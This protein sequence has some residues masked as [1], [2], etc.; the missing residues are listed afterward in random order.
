MTEM[1]VT[2]TAGTGHFFTNPRIICTWRPL[3][4]HAGYVLPVIAVAE[5]DPGFY[6]KQLLYVATD[7]VIEP[8]SGLL[9]NVG[10]GGDCETILLQFI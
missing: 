6:L 5:G 10:K 1:A 9:R 8:H 2:P 4:C 7:I 3:N